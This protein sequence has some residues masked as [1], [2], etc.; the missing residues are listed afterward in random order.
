MSTSDPKV[1]CLNA[2]STTHKKKKAY[3]NENI[4]GIAY[5][6]G[7]G[8]PEIRIHQAFSGIKDTNKELVRE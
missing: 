8:R 4:Y 2:W 3:L 1:N 7:L 6:T 5:F